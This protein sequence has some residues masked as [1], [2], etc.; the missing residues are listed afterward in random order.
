[1]K[2]LNELWNVFPNS[3][4]TSYSRFLRGID[5][6]IKTAF[7]EAQ[8]GWANLQKSLLKPPH[9]RLWRGEAKND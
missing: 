6:G 7:T 5:G 8:D 9:E 2:P 3:P 4:Q 1:M